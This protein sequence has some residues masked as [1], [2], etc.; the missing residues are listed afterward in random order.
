[1]CEQPWIMPWSM[2]GPFGKRVLGRMLGDDCTVLAMIGTDASTPFTAR[3]ACPK[4]TPETFA[5]PWTSARTGREE[6][7]HETL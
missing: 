3:R 1:M 4:R 5:A 6:N 2:G 7:Y